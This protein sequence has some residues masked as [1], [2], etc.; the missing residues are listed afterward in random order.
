MEDLVHR[1]V[2]EAR[3]DN[4]CKATRRCITTSVT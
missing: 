3:C 1:P 2:G 4:I